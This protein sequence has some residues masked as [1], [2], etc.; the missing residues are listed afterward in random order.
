M[1]E[2][3]NCFKFFMPINSLQKYCPECLADSEVVKKRNRD[4]I[5]RLRERRKQG[6]YYVERAA[7]NEPGGKT[8]PTCKRPFKPRSN[9]QVWCLECRKRGRQAART[10]YMRKYLAEYRKRN[11]VKTPFA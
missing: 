4:R 1:K 10:R 7:K 2:C 6:V 11:R 8:C 3:L 5:A 9:R